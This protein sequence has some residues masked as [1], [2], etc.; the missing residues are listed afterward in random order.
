MSLNATIFPPLDI[1]TV[2][3]DFSRLVLSPDGS[4]PDLLQRRMGLYVDLLDAE[5]TSRPAWQ[6]SPHR[7]VVGHS[8]GGMLAMTWWLAHGGAGPAG[9]DGMV[10]CSTTA[11]P[12]FE[13]A[14]L[15]HFRASVA[16]FVGF[17]NY[18]LVTR[19]VKRLLSGGIDRVA[20]VDFRSLRSTSDFSIDA[21]G[22]RNTDW[23]AMRSYRFA[24]EGFDVRRRLGAITVP[25]IVLHGDRDPLLPPALGRELAAELPNAE[26]RLVRN[27]GHGLPVTHGDAVR[28]AIA[29]LL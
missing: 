18:P 2:T 1:P 9:V 17:W 7:I 19:A 13:V 11:G 3:A 22:W 20:P 5:L 8:F 12:L 4:S 23:R 24:L 15:G 25:V 27:A 16:P 14:R 29:A 28:E 21:A 10:L 6:A 26:F